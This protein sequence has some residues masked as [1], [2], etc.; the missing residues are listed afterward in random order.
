MGG[1]SAF[2]LDTKVAS[3]RDNGVIIPIILVVVS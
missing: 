2:Y 1:G 3:K